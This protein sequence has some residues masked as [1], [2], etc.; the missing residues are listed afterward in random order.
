[1]LTTLVAYGTSST[2]DGPGDDTKMTL[3]KC[4]LLTATTLLIA[5]MWADNV[6]YVGFE[7][8]AGGDYDYNDLIFSLSGDGITL[9]TATGQWSPEPALGTNGAPFWN[10][11]SWDGPLF[12]VGYCI[13]GGGNCNGGSGLAPSDEY[14]AAS[15][16]GPA[17]DVYF[18]VDN[19]TPVSSPVYLH[20]AGDTDLV[21][22]YLLSDPS[23]IHWINSPSDVTDGTLS[24]NPGGA[25]GLVGN[26]N[27]GT[28]GNTFFSQTSI[29]GTA[30]PFGSHFAFFGNGNVSTVP[31]PGSLMLFGTALLGISVVLRRRKS[32]GQ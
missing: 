13:Y 28:G 18:T 12:N 1:M 8:V 4:I 23:V 20:I 2:C 15:G 9:Q 21:G 26:D 6:Y 10:H 24:F 14:L 30:D 22:W 19:T 16:G 5:P 27:G 7:D 3:T 25:F 31:E 17:N 32:A 29:G 11:A